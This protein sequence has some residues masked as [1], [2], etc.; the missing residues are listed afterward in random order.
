MY[1]EYFFEWELIIIKL[2]ILFYNTLFQI[3]LKRLI[4]K[5]AEHL[6]KYVPNTNG[7]NIFAYLNEY[8]IILMELF[9]S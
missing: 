9:H 2:I 1:L 3:H 4:S 5:N 7:S 6:P 8:N